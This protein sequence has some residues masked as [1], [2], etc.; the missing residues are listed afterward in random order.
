M[1]DNLPTGKKV[2]QARRH[3]NSSQ[4]NVAAIIEMEH[5]AL[6][7]RTTSQRISD[8]IARHAGKMWFLVAHLIWFAVWLTWNSGYFQTKPFDPFPFQFLSSV[9]SLEAIFLSLVILMSQ[10]RASRQA[11]AR[12]HLDLQINLLA[13]QESTKTL[14]LLQ[15]LCA[16]H[17]IGAEHDTEI[18]ELTRTTQPD[19]LLKE[20][21]EKLPDNA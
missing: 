10:N 2:S 6:Q 3:A 5:A 8:V 21:K 12:A 4:S 17:G 20:L 19:E 1:N 11:D 7:A 16:H 18:E 13:E 9:L 15:M 14:Q